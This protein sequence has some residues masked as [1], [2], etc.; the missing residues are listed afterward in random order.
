ML[1]N[2]AE[3]EKETSSAKFMTFLAKFVPA[4][5]CLC[6]LLPESSGG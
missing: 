4:T 5:R 1:K 2:P 3:H 6:Q